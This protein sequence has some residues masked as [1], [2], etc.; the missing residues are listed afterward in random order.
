MDRLKEKLQRIIFGVDTPAGR[1]F[2]VA[3][4]ILIIASITIL[5]LESVQEINTKWAWLFKYL[6]WVITALFTVEY[7]LRLWVA[8]F[9]AT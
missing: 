3:L 1:A 4:L 5:M 2:D 8:D 7:L 9:R 6:D